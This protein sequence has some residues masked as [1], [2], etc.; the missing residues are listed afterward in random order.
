MHGIS[1]SGKNPH[2]RIDRLIEIDKK[3]KRKVFLVLHG[4]SGTPEEDL[5]RAINNGI[6]KVNV[7][8]ELR[9]A[10]TKALKKS[11]EKNPDQTTPYKIMPPVVDAVQD[12]VENK[13]V[14]FGSDYKI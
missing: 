13:I 3:L 1:K 11:L 14:L 4:G 6:T 9:V 7:N 5:I 8:T 2:L 12:I 10:Y